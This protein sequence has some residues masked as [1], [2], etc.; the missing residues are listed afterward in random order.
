MRAAGKTEE[1]EA[2]GWSLERAYWRD[3]L[4]GWYRTRYGLDLDPLQSDD[5]IVPPEALVRRVQGA[6]KAKPDVFFAGGYRAIHAYLTELDDYGFKPNEMQRI[7]EFGVGFGRLLLHFA[8]LPAKLFG[9]D[10]TKTAIDWATDKLGH[11]AEFELTPLA[12][13]LPYPDRYFDFI[14]AN[15]VFT[16]IAHDLQEKWIAELRRIV[17]PGGCVVTSHLDANKYFQHYSWRE[18][19]QKLGTKGWFQEGDDPLGIGTFFYCEKK[20]LF[21]MWGKYFE[22]LELRTQFREQSQLI[23]RAP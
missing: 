12:P 20:K 19:H 2:S 4:R 6:R 22:L 8:P 13:P 9:C 17:K 5:A 3:V 16:H 1:N 7:L 10:I 14:Y 21:E 11:K 23:V 15:S 18:L